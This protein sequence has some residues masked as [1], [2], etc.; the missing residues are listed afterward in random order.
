M[1]SIDR[2]VFLVHLCVYLDGRDLSRLRAVCK[3]F[4]DWIDPSIRKIR[5]HWVQLNSVL[6]VI[7]ETNLC[8]VKMITYPIRVDHFMAG[9]EGFRRFTSKN[10]VCYMNDFYLRGNEQRL[11][12]VI[13]RELRTC[14][15]KF[16]TYPPLTGNE[17]HKFCGGTI[18]RGAS[19]F[20]E[21]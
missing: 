16:I 14:A 18:H 4:N 9:L 21:Y 8:D 6:E 17:R 15:F 3:R 10:H 19:L 13:R 20:V 1:D 5:W 12:E 11:D 7:G 2:N